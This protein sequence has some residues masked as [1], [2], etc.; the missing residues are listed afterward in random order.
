MAQT[1]AAQLAFH[2]RLWAWFET[3]RQQAL[4][5][6]VALVIIGFGTS[7]YVWRAGEREAA[8]SQELSNQ[9]ADRAAIEATNLVPGYLRIADRYSGTSAAGR[10]ILLAAANLFA[11]GKYSDARAQFTRFLNAYANSSFSGQAM[12][13][14][15]A[16]HDAEGK[17]DEAIKAYENFT[18]SR[19][20]DIGVRQAKFALARLYESQNKLEQ[21]R[22]LYQELAP[23]GA[24][25]SIAVEAGMRL[26]ELLA[27]NPNL[28]PRAP[29]A[30]TNTPQPFV[31]QKQ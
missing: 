31:I 22:N 6:A 1:D 28:I 19:P 11:E 18:K 4:I 12:L 16:C 26:E 13:G 30:T 21:A 7:F 5:G 27:K 8:A 25:D 3:H 14:V 24:N 10:A 20:N 29:V 9:A 23:Q 15:A 2:E 17:T